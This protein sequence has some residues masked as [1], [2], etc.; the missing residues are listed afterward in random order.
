MVIELVG[1]KKAELNGR[2]G[3][4]CSFDSDK[5]RWKVLVER[6]LGYLLV[7][8]ENIKIVETDSYKSPDSSASVAQ[9]RPKAWEVWADPD[10]T[11]TV[12][13]IKMRGAEEVPLMGLFHFPINIRNPNEKAERDWLRKVRGWN[14]PQGFNPVDGF[15]TDGGQDGKYLYYD[16]GDSTGPIN[17]W[18]NHVLHLT[19]DY[20]LKQLPNFQ[21]G[22]IHGNVIVMSAP[23]MGHQFKT[24]SAQELRAWVLSLCTDKGGDL[25]RDNTPGSKASFDSMM[26]DVGGMPSSGVGFF[27]TFSGPKL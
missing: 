26:A 6:A 8:P 23:H 7:K 18:A 19:P 27:N 17:H 10:S 20:R 1:L 22:G 24:Y 13:N 2:I 16:N 14:D 4:L 5:G 15:F 21:E 12:E 25:S 9:I 11:F 3:I